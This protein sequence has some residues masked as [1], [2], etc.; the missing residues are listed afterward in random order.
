MTA[1]RSYIGLGSSIIGWATR[2]K[3][4]DIIGI[5]IAGAVTTVGYPIIAHVFGCANGDDVFAGSWRAN[6]ACAWAIV[7]SRKNVRHWLQAS[8]G[9]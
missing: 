2:R 5:V 9:R 8:G 7:A 4:N 1:G 6:R 3:A